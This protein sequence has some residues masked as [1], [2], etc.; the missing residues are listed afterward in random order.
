MLA[1]KTLLISFS[2]VLAQS[3]QVRAQVRMPDGP[4]AT[5]TLTEFPGSIVS[6][7]YNEI[8]LTLNSGRVLKIELPHG[9]FGRPEQACSLAGNRVLLFGDAGGGGDTTVAII[10]LPANRLIDTFYAYRPALSPNRTWLAFRRFYPLTGAIDPSEQYMIY[11]LRK[12]AL[13]YR[14]VDVVGLDAPGSPVYPVEEKFF[15]HVEIPDDERHQS[16]SLFFWSPDS[17]AVLFADLHEERTDLVLVKIGDSRHTVL[18]RPTDPLKLCRGPERPG[19]MPM[20]AA[21]L[22]P[23]GPG[24]WEIVADFSGSCRPDPLIVSNDEFTPARVQQHRP[25]PAPGQM[26]RTDK[27]PR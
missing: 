17:K 13:E 2:L 24:R 18:V 4:C 14:T 7:S 11:D 22:T 16:R 9:I 19:Y 12:A 5:N 23:L 20:A 3:V 6:S 27:P 25:L 26:I 8:V 15:M 1:S 10:D 21:R